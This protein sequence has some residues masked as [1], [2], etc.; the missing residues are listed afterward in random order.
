MYLFWLNHYWSN[1]IHVWKKNREMQ[2][3]EIH[4]LLKVSIFT[5]RRYQKADQDTLYGCLLLHKSL[6]AKLSV[7]GF[8]ISWGSYTETLFSFNRLL[9][10][11]Q[12]ND[13]LESPSVFSSDSQSMVPRPATSGLSTENFVDM[14]IIRCR[15]LD[16]LHQSAICMS[17]SSSED[18]DSHSDLRTTD[19]MSILWT[20]CQLCK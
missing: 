6:D 13:V 4:L 14:H 16:F 11:L 1:H 18:S 20:Q 8:E 19:V 12:F 15:T 3:Q 10:F 7:V 9:V 5:E 2:M 17:T